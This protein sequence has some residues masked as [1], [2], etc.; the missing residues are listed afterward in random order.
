MNEMFWLNFQ[1]SK[2]INKCEKDNVTKKH[3]FPRIWFYIFVT[4]FW[5]SLIIFEFCDVSIT[6]LTK[7]FK[8]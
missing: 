1:I 3:K 4:Y 6:R 5:S 2:D 7:A 8:F